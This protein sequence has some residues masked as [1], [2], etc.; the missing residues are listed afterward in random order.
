MKCMFLFISG[1]TAD[2]SWLPQQA[3]LLVPERGR[4][5][6]S[7]PRQSSQYPQQ[8]P[9]RLH[10]N[11]PPPRPTG[12]LPQHPFI[13]CLTSGPTLQGRFWCQRGTALPLPS[14]YGSKFR[15]ILWQSSPWRQTDCSPVPYPREEVSLSSKEKIYWQGGC[16]SRC[17]VHDKRFLQK[18]KSCWRQLPK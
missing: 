4:A 12:S 17:H 14:P 3:S 1:G 9:E 6:S 16:S 10:R 2:G 15:A 11:P 5:V 7:V 8:Q 18:C 13:P